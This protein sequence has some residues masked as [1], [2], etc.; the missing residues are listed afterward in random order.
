[1]ENF[2][3]EIEIRRKLQDKESEI[4]IDDDSF[5]MYKQN[6]ENKIFSS[7]GSNNRSFTINN[8]NKFSQFLALPLNKK[9]TA[10]KENKNIRNLIEQNSFNSIFHYLCMNEGNLPLLKIIKPTSNEINRK[11][12]YDQT[13]LHI[14]VINN[15][16]KILKFL[17]SDNNVNINSIDKQKNTP[18]HY[19]ITLKNFE[20]IKLLIGKH[21]KM[22]IKNKKGETPIDIAKKLNIKNQIE[23]I[24]NSNR[25]K[26]Q[27]S[28]SP[29]YSK[30]TEKMKSLD[31]SKKDFFKKSN[32]FIFSVSFEYEGENEI[33]R[34]FK[35]RF[36]YFK[37]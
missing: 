33:I 29:S 22:T 15:T 11:N 2:Q 24:Y 13:L 17:L 5:N 10:Y 1:M 16:K 9:I 18:L 21:A 32:D 20:L 23:N 14:S 8:S 6:Q 12:K 28:F 27:K 37:R 35:K 25:N 36:F 3:Q 19:A 26:T 31:F 4:I 34:F 30:E 7:L